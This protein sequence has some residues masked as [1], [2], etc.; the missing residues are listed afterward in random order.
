[1][2]GPSESGDFGNPKDFCPLYALDLGPRE[3]NGLPI[4]SLLLHGMIVMDGMI[5]F[6]H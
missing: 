4:V 3:R 1:M 5:P 6:V 2:W